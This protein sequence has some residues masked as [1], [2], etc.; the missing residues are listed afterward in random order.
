[1]I[2]YDRLES[3]VSEPR[4]RAALDGVAAGVVGVIAA[5]AVSLAAGLYDPVGGRLALFFLAAVALV[6]LYVI[7]SRYAPPVVILLA[8]LAGLALAAA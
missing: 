2:F 6:A 3:I 4:I 5:T 8:G 7:K 1:M